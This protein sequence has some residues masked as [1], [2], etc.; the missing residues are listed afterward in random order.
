MHLSLDQDGTGV[1]KSPW[2]L[3][4]PKVPT[5]GRPEA[6]GKVQKPGAVSVEAELGWEAV[7]DSSFWELL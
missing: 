6:L 7:A 4:I 5:P 3:I 2:G 1:G